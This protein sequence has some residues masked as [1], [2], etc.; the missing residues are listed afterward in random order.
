MA[1]AHPILGSLTVTDIMKLGL[2]ADIHCDMD[3]LLR[4][5]ELVRQHGVDAI[6]CAGDLVGKGLGVKG[7]A[8]V[9]LIDQQAIP[10]VQGNHDR[11]AAGNQKWLCENGDPDHP[12]LR[13]M[14]LGK[15]TLE[16]LQRL[17]TTLLMECAGRRVLVAHGSPWS[18]MDYVYASSPRIV[19][20]R[21]M[22]QSHADVIVLGHTHR[23]MNV[24]FGGLQ[25][26]N[27]G[28]VC[29]E[30]AGGSATCGILTLPAGRFEVYDL[31]CGLNMPIAM[32]VLG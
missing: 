17:P 23:P 14:L 27:P 1:R 10:C 4:A 2:I 24:R 9:D 25:V 3:G 5:L 15:P 8:V 18:Q 11:V 16:M 6:L 13:E 32:T 29:G 28:S 12:R 26:V 31:D 30:D 19:Y 20:E 22:Q 7:D 21:L